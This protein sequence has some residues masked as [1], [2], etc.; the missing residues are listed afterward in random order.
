MTKFR[1]KQ[2]PEEN[3]KKGRNIKRRKI[4]KKVSF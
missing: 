4:N 3:I 2:M 1:N